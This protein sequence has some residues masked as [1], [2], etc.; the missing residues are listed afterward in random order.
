MPS[1]ERPRVNLTSSA[2]EEVLRLKQRLT[3]SSPTQR[4]S[5]SFGLVGLMSNAC[6]RGRGAG[7]EHDTTTRLDGPRLGSDDVRSLQPVAH[8][9]IRS[10]GDL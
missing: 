8:C 6:V 10:G 3:S 1:A 2:R 5:V 4:R 9:P 7:D